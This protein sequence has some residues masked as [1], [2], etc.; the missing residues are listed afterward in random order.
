MDPHF[1]ESDTFLPSGTE[2][3][4]KGDRQIRG[5]TDRD[6]CREVGKAQLSMRPGEHVSPTENHGKGEQ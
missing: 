3:K 2:V 5:M 1:T 6:T 4:S